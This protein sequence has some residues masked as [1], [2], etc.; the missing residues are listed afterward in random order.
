MSRENVRLSRRKRAKKAENPW[1]STPIRGPN[2]R[3]AAVSG[4]ERVFDQDRILALGAGGQERHRSLDQLLD[5]P[6]VLDGLGRQLGPAARAPGRAVPAGH[7]L[8]DRL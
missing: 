7:G 6:D 3:P 4:Q 5:A 1:P 2:L 8:V